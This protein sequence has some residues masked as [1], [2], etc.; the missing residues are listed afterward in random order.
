VKGG[1]LKRQN[2]V[3]EGTNGEK[4]ERKKEEEEN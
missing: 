4:N 1:I 2:L 3:R